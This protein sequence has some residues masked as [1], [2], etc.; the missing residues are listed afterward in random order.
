MSTKMW[1]HELFRREFFFWVRS[2]VKMQLWR[3]RSYHTRIAFYSFIIVY[4]RGNCHLNRPTNENLWIHD[5][6][7]ITWRRHLFR[8]IYFVEIFRRIV[9]NRLIFCRTT[10][11]IIDNLC[12]LHVFGRHFVDKINDSSRWALQMFM[13]NIF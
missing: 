8:K 1:P 7:L 11:K 12:L 3:L 10:T 9:Y 4:V 2:I 13:A 5:F 6:N